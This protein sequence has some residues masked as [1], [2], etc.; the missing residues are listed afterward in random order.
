[1]LLAVPGSGWPSVHF[2]SGGPVIPGLKHL[3]LVIK[4]AFS[5]ETVL[6]EAVCSLVRH[7]EALNAVRCA[8]DIQQT[9]FVPPRLLFRMVP[10]MF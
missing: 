9:F 1:M 8:V 7:T 5:G 6:N 10:N 4:A 3:S 2:L